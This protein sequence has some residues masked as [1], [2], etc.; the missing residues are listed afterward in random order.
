MYTIIIKVTY[1]RINSDANIAKFQQRLSDVKWQE[2]L[3][4]NDAD[5]DYNKF[6]E[7]FDTLYNECVSLKKCTNNKKRTNV[8]VDH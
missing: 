1:K 2:I 3:D 6:I 7:T 5:D 8:P 4:N